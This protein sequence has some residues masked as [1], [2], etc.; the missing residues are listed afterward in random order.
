MFKMLV[1]QTLYML[2]DD[3]TECQIWDRLSFMRFIGVALEGRVPDA[4]PIWLFREQ[5]TKAGVGAPPA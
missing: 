2:S 4:K 1:L 5:L 3:Q